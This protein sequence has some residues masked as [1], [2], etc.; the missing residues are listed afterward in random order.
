MRLSMKRIEYIAHTNKSRKLKIILFVILVFAVL[1]EIV[2]LSSPKEI[3]FG[4]EELSN[5]KITEIAKN[6]K[7]L[8][9]VVKQ[10]GVKAVMEKLAAETGGGSFLDCHQGAHYI[11]RAAYNVYKEEAFQ[12]CDSSC[13]SGCYHGA[14]EGILIEK[15]SIDFLGNLED[16]CTSF[17]RAFGVFECYHGLG[18]AIL[19]Y[20]NYDLPGTLKQCKELSNSFGFEINACYAGAFMENVVTGQGLG[21]A[22]SPHATEWLN[23]T[24]PHFPCN[25]IDQ[26]YSIQHECYGMQTSWM[27][28][29]NHYN[30]DEA[31]GECYNVPENM[32]LVCFQ[33]LGRDIA[34]YTLR[35]PERIAELCGKVP[36][37]KHYYDRCIDGALNVILDFWGPGLKDQATAL[38]RLVEEPSKR[39]CYS[40]LA[41]AL[42]FIFLTPEE[43]E[44]VCRSFEEKY[45]NLCAPPR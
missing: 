11:G 27:L 44:P 38:C 21:T 10:V 4:A 39:S 35:K 32:V 20:L 26:E 24:D 15:G 29:L 43:A 2:F 6:E 30:F 16:I 40:I 14:M 41:N 13:H 42:S 7:V 33:S 22:K 25:K 18:H 8:Q 31:I 34:G 1:L 9:A 5:I 28:Y 3:K 12:R 37:D 19:A 17:D 23:T 45:R 36:K